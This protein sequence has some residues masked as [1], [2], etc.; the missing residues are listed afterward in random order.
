M[1]NAGTTAIEIKSGYG[2]TVKDELKMLRVIRRLQETYSDMLIR[3][4]LL[5]AHALPKITKQIEAVGLI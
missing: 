2:L 4:T 3:P 1:R 5:A